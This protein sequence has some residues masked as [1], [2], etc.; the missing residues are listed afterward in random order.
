MRMSKVLGNY[1]QCLLSDQVVIE[2]VAIIKGFLSVL[3]IRMAYQGIVKL[4]EFDQKFR[5]Y[6]NSYLIDCSA[7]R[8]LARGR[9]SAQFDLS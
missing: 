8:F 6:M 7:F 1:D 3:C 4:S 9:K 2:K 5:P